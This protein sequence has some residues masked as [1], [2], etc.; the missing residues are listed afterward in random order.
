LELIATWEHPGPGSY[1]DDV[2]NTAKSPHVLRSEVVVTEPGEEAQPEPTY[3]WWDSGRSR[4][5]LSWQTSMNWP[6]AVVYEGLDPD[7][8]YTVR[9]TGYNESL[10]RMDGVRVKPTL[11]GRE[12]G[13]FK[14][15]PVPPEH[16]QDRKLVLTWDQPDE[17]QLN[18]RQKSRLA[19]I[20]LLKQPG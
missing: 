3:W 19:E 1:Y 13:Q 5:R 20:W 4:A 15:F 10:L 18:W 2:G 7:A 12:M 16:I 8:T 17:G 14:E 6:L 9:L 11:D